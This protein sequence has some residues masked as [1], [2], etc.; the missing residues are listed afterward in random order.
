MKAMTM[1]AATALAGA[2]FVASPRAPSLCMRW[3]SR[4]VATAAENRL[5]L[6][7]HTGV[8][9]L[10][11][12]RKTRDAE[13]V[14]ALRKSALMSDQAPIHAANAAMIP[15]AVAAMVNSRIQR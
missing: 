11:G 8:M 14:G 1:A 13:K 3:P 10:L 12:W 4:L 6:A 5:S 15:A 7:K 2:L 9:G